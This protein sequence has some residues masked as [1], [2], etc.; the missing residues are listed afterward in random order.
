MCQQGP[1]PPL[2]DS[3]DVCDDSV[4]DERGG[5]PGVEQQRQQLPLA[6]RQPRR[7]EEQ[8]ELHE[9]GVYVL[10]L[11]LERDLLE[12]DEFVLVQ[13]SVVG[14]EGPGNEMSYISEYSY[15]AYLIAK[16]HLSFKKIRHFI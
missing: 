15:I 8:V 13:S 2:D 16:N 9:V 6:R 1:A 7:A 5:H 14:F 4:L 12:V 3:L 10:H 11:N